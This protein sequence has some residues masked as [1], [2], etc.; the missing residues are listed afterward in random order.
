MTADEDDEYDRAR[1][2]SEARVAS[3]TLAQGGSTSA[4]ALEEAAVDART[5][6]NAA[7][8]VRDDGDDGQEVQVEK[9]RKRRQGFTFRVQGRK[10]H[11][12]GSGAGGGEDGGGAWAAAKRQKSGKRQAP[13]QPPPACT[14]DD[15]A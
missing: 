2:Q 3:V 10:K 6:P 15:H 5:V 4:I 11:G 8:D 13:C 7:T 14:D 1:E 9:K 12:G